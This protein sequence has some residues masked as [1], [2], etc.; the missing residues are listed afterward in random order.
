MGMKNNG[1]GLVL[2]STT[3]VLPG[4]VLLPII[5]YNIVQHLAAAVI[6]RFVLRTPHP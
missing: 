4:P 1:A 6:D 2:V 5:I 3:F